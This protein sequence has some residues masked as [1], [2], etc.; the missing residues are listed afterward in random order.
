MTEDSGQMS[1]GGRRE[2]GSEGRRERPTF[3]EEAPVFG[4]SSFVSDFEIRYSDFRI[5]SAAR[6]SR[7]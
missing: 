6:Q 1:E 3:N 2:I 5:F 4:F 7:S